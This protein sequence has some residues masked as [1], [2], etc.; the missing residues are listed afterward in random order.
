VQFVR[1]SDLAG[2][3]KCGRKVLNMGLFETLRKTVVPTLCVVLLCAVG[4]S[5]AKN[6]KTIASP[7]K[8]NAPPAP[9]VITEI[10]RRHLRSITGTNSYDSP[11]SRGRDFIFVGKSRSPSDGWRVFIVRGSSGKPV[12]IWDSDSLDHDIYFSGMAP[13]WMDSDADGTDGYFVAVRGCAPHQCA[14]GRLGFALFASRTYRTYVSHITTK[15]DGS[16]AVTYSP[17]SGIPEIYRKQLDRMMCSDNGVLHPA[18]LPIKCAI[19]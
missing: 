16:Y 9:L 6:Q 4:R 3:G 5:A 7:A 11:G 2:A 8:Q 14:D 1:L 13:D 12:V 15:D 10:A 19:R 18:A 17:K